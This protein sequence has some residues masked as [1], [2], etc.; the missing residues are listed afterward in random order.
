VETNLKFE[1]QN[2]LHVIEPSVN[3]I[4]LFCL[5]RQDDIIIIHRL[6]IRHAWS[7]LR[8]ET[9]P[10]QFGPHWLIWCFMA[11]CSNCGGGKPVRMA[12][13]IHCIIPYIA[14]KHSHCTNAITSYLIVWPTCM[15]APPVYTQ[16]VIGSTHSAVK[17]RLAR[18]CL[19]IKWELHLSSLYGTIQYQY[20]KNLRTSGHKLFVYGPISKMCLILTELDV[21]IKKGF[22]SFPPRL[23]L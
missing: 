20:K 3:V 6:R 11:I 22:Y 8:G 1:S 12:N 9:P 2:Q 19:F 10:L 15:L 13:K 16:P 7:L 17:A 14:V 4:N 23:P 5:P 18:N 21:P